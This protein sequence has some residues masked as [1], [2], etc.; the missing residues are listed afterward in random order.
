MELTRNF[1]LSEFERSETAS[2]RGIPNKVPPELI[3]HVQRVANWLQI[4]RERLSARLGRDTPIVL[5]SG[6][7]SPQLNKVV[8]GSLNS[9][10]M[11][12]LAVD[13]RVP[14][15]SVSA[16]MHLVLQLMPDC[17]YDQCIDEFD[18]WIHL[19]LKEDPTHFR[20]QN[21][22]ARKIKGKTVYELV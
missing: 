2:R 8:G 14:N 13:F 10:H 19:G 18:S 1:N 3:P 21:L 16:L 5:L 20:R 7:R 15:H 12:G 17:P 9:A 4:F 11:Q 22:R 6:Y